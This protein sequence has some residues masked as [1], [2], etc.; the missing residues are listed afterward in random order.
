[1][2]QRCSRAVRA[3]DTQQKLCRLGRAACDASRLWVVT[4]TKA[5]APGTLFRESQLKAG[6]EQELRPSE[7]SV[8]SC[9]LQAR[10][11][12]PTAAVSSVPL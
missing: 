10:L 1:M 6:R 4:F 3:M 8:G 9:M 11:C 2:R 5:H 7:V 12:S